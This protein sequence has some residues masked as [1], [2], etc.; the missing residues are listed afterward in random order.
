METR[1]P[2]STTVPHPA[3]MMG[4]ASLKQLLPEANC[5]W[6]LPGGQEALIGKNPSSLLRAAAEVSRPS[7]AAG[8]RQLLL[9]REQLRLGAGAHI[10]RQEA[11]RSHTQEGLP[12]RTPAAVSM[13]LQHPRGRSQD[14]HTTAGQCWA[15]LPPGAV[16][17]AASSLP[18]P[19]EWY[20]SECTARLRTPSKGHSASELMDLGK[21]T[22]TCFLGVALWHSRITRCLASQ[23]G[24]NLGPHCFISE[25]ALC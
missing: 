4:L 9:G 19:W 3:A 16:L 1:P 18:G 5:E 22:T 6:L 13:C 15:S 25:Q 7:L 21:L 14:T 20:T 24:T 23:M 11:G 17:T 10:F 8:S 2:C 12:G